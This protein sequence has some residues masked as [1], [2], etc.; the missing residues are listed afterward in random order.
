[1]LSTAEQLLG[2]Y[3]H[4]GEYALGPAKAGLSNLEFAG[5]ALE[6]ATRLRASGVSTAERVSAIGQSAGIGGPMLR[7]I[8]QTLKA[9]EWVESVE[10]DGVLIRVSEQVPPEPELVA[11]ADD[12]LSMCVPT[13]VER[14]VLRLLDETTIMPLTVTKALE[15]G[16]EV[17]SEE[18]AERAL[19]YLKS[20][21]LAYVGRSA[22]GTIVVCNPNVWAT[23]VDYA[24][25]ALK[26]EDSTVHA[27]VSGLIEEIAASPGL[28]EDFVRSAEPKWVHFAV[29]Q[30]LVLRSL[31]QTSDGKNRG[32][33]FVPH[34]ARNAFQA[35]TGADPSGHVRQLIGSMVFA[36]NFAQHG[37]YSPPA[38]LRALV[39]D[40]EAG[41]ASDIGTDYPML[42]TSGIMKVEPGH[43]YF[44]LVLLQAD[45]AE[46]ALSYLQAADTPVGR[47]VVKG[48]RDQRTYV[49]PE[50]ER[51]RLG[52]VATDVPAETERLIAALRETA[53]GRDFGR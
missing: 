53:A 4:L 51:A 13:P 44:K 33:L 48:L 49:H 17:S 10:K 52:K 18:D 9:L 20:L 28:P 30:G 24:A 23:D 38:F 8:L 41:D 25:A 1:M 39:R 22:D 15:I 27:A 36:K 37:L 19:D 11:K 7:L 21:N 43:K 34:M 6:M 32:F 29:S 2:L 42:E 5:A 12:V 31:V 40:G 3:R 45:V 46:S 35:P 16:S 50:Q 26:A 47:Q 14:T